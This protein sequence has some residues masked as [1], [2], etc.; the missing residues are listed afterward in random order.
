M[1]VTI[2][3]KAPNTLQGAPRGAPCKK[4][5]SLLSQLLTDDDVV[6]TAGAAGPP[7]A[8]EDEL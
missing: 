5:V 2:R 4:S 1:P 6:T 8:G 7:G 3:R